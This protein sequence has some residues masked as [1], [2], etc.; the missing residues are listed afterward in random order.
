MQKSLFLLILQEGLA[1]N[2]IPLF[3]PSIIGV[4]FTILLLQH[5]SLEAVVDELFILIV[6]QLSGV[7]IGSYLCTL[8]APRL[9][10]CLTAQGT[11]KFSSGIG[12]VSFHLVTCSRHGA[13]DGLRHLNCILYII[14]RVLLIC[15]VG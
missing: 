9:I 15:P 7:K 1:V 13:T 12:A 3:Q 14:L 5:L 6:S 4:L 8:I 2:L 10:R 11:Q